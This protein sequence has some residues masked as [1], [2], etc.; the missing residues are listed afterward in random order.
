[1]FWIWSRI[2]VGSQV[3]KSQVTNMSQVMGNTKSEPRVETFRVLK[4]EPGD[5][6]DKVARVNIDVDPRWCE[7]QLALCKLH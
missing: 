4:L 2:S 1:M 7:K 5:I 3:K 6:A